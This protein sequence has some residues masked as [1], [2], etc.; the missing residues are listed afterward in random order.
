VPLRVLFL[1]D[2]HLGLGL[3]GRPRVERPRR[4]DDLFASFERALEPA[5]RREADVV[6]HGGDLFYRSRVPAWLAARV[7][8][9]LA[10]LADAGVDLFWVPGNHERGAVPREL[11]LTHPRVRVFDRPR[12]FLLSR[13]GVTLA[14]AGFPYAPRIRDDA[15]ALLG[16]TGAAAVPADVRLLC[17]HQAVEGATV[18]P[19]DYVFRS[20][21]DVLRGR[22]VPSGFA[23][24]LSG[25]IHRAQVLTRDLAGRPLGAP[26]LFAGSTARVSFAERFEPKGSFLLEVSADGTP[27]GRAAWAFRE[28]PVRPMAVVDL[29][30]APSGLPERIVAALAPLAPRCLVRLRLLAEPPAES[31]PLLR[32]DAVRARAPA[33]FDV[34]VAWPRQEGT[35]TGAPPSP[36]PASRSDQER[37]PAPAGD[38]GTQLLFEDFRPSQPNGPEPR[39]AMKRKR[40]A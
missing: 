31:L 28:H 7:F 40:S 13:D 17:V 14:L 30:P 25:H 3:P 32:P 4:G 15:P 36:D 23:A 8:A 2:T 38:G 5:L 19:A 27:G 24:V 16:A 6:V 12:T 1:S 11:L 39:Q 9:R 33:G 21:A 37:F 34:S 26:V 22:D 29:D 18:G 20:G 10:D 35:A